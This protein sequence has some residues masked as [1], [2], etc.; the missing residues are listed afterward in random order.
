MRRRPRTRPPRETR[1]EVRVSVRFTR[2][3]MDTRRDQSH[4]SRGSVDDRRDHR[5]GRSPLRVVS[6]R[7]QRRLAVPR[8]HGIRIGV[9][10]SNGPDTSGR[11]PAPGR[12]LDSL[13]RCCYSPTEGA[14]KFCEGRALP[15]RLPHLPAEPER[16]EGRDLNPWTS[17]GADLESAAVSELGYPR[18]RQ[19]VARGPISVLW[20]RARSGPTNGTPSHRPIRRR[21][22]PR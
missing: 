22:S 18:T 21:R 13:R 3:A 19:G 17:T 7:P 15:E 10:S 20:F 5:H 4:R 1:S 11:L 8:R 2:Y 12:R 6:R 14:V 9:R 16:C